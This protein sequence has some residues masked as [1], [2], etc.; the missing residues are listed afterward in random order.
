MVPL[1]HASR[2]V[3]DEELSPLRCALE[4][5]IGRGADS[6]MRAVSSDMSGNGHEAHASDIQHMSRMI[7]YYG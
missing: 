5:L 7:I 4:R 1:Q 3:L 2:E 6:F